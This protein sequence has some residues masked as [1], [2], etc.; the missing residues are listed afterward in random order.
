VSE[1]APAQNHESEEA[2]HKPGSLWIL[3]AIVG[4]LVAYPLSIGPMAKFYQGRR[5]PTA[6]E[7]L[8]APIASLYYH[9]PAAHKALEWY[10]HLW[11]I[12]P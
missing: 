10:L 8:Y 11:G 6:V 1:L 2:H 9:S 4:L 3:W 12:K 5:A 7:T